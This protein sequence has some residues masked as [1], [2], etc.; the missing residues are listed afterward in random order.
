MDIKRCRC[1]DILKNKLIEEN[2]EKLGYIPKYY[3]H[4]VLC[5]TTDR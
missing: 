4:F 2:N 3:T 1:S 5:K